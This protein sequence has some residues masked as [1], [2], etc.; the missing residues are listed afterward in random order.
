MGGEEAGGR[1]EGRGEEKSGRLVN[2]LKENRKPYFFSHHPILLYIRIYLVP[3]NFPG[4]KRI[5]FSTSL[6]P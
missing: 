1:E 4:P 6:F 3:Q 2:I 5:F